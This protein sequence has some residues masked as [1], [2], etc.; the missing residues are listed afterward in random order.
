MS[1][2]RFVPAG[3]LV[4][5]PFCPT[6]YQR[7]G[8]TCYAYNTSG[9]TFTNT[10]SYCSGLASGD[11]AATRDST[12]LDA[13][14]EI[15]GGAAVW[16]GGKAASVDAPMQWHPLK[17]TLAGVNALTNG[18]ISEW[19]NSTML[20]RQSGYDCLSLPSL[21]PASCSTNKRA[22]CVKAADAGCPAGFLR[23]GS[24]CVYASMA[25]ATFSAARASCA[26]LT[27]E[28]YEPR[29]PGLMLHVRS[30]VAT[31]NSGDHWI[32]L[33][34]KYPG[35]FR[36]VS[37]HSSPLFSFFDE[38][39]GVGPISDGSSSGPC[40]KMAANGQLGSSDCDDQ[41]HFIC[42]YKPRPLCPAGFVSFGE[43][44]DCFYHMVG[45]VER[46]GAQARCAAL[47][48]AL[49]E[50]RETDTLNSFRTWHG[51]TASRLW[52]GVTDLG[53]NNKFTTSDGLVPTLLPWGTGQGGDTSLGCTSLDRNVVADSTCE[54]S[55]ADG[56]LCV[57][58]PGAYRVR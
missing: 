31:I 33:Q 56:Y 51:N 9:R 48:A 10:K 47:G 18:P 57:H 24:A 43:T 41:K 52:T 49:G 20:P 29:E 45:S 6:G 26:S 28:L 27:S 46:S 11:M 2:H 44:S 21:T 14:S 19:A 17:S 5:S 7:R 36:F 12:E 34:E 54:S 1:D 22:L 25:P 58:S 38:S 23:S 53:E 8:S 16:L 50:I 3:S 35:D 42:L 13:F 39:S 30:L 55:A 32:G 37:D 4:P 40:V 15:T